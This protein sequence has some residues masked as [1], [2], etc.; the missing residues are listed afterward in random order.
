MRRN[1]FGFCFVVFIAMSLALVTN[2][3]AQDKTRGGVFESLKG[4]WYRLDGG[5]VIEIKNIE[6][7]G[8]MEAAYFNPRPINVSQAEVKDV[9]GRVEVFI[10]LRDRGYPG[11]TYTLTYDDKRDELGGIYF[12]AGSKREFNVTFVRMKQ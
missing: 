12:H 10:K 2:S 11:S 1:L 8:K 4:K 6:P 5:Y 3:F 7:S 9:D